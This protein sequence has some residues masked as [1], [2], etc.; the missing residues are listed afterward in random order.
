MCWMTYISF[1][2]FVFLK[3]R[4]CSEEVFKGKPCENTK[5]L[6]KFTLYAV[7]SRGGVISRA[8]AETTAKAS[9]TCH[10]EYNLNHLNLNESSSS[11]NLFKRIGYVRRLA[12]T[13]KD[14]IPEKLKAE[15]ETPTL[16]YCKKNQ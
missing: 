5:I 11:K 9:I 3:N 8:V 16:G 10:P 14:E 1:K 6:L 13:G 4:F 12:T 7:R 15:I 2:C